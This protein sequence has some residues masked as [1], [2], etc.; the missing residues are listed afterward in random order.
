MTT[1]NETTSTSAQIDTHFYQ[2]QK[3]SDFGSEDKCAAST[4]E[5]SQRMLDINLT[6]RRNPLVDNNPVTFRIDIKREMDELQR[7]ALNM[8]FLKSL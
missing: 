8:R 6:V 3:Q 7:A 5:S 2:T 1:E 4:E